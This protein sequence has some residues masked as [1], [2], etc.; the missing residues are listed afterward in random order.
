MKIEGD[1]LWDKTGEPDPEVQQLEEILG[2]LRYQPKPLEIPADLQIGRQRNF[3]RGFAPGLAIAATIA[4][5]L[6]GLALWVG[7]QRLQRGPSEVSKTSSKPESSSN[8]NPAT[9]LLPNKDQDTSASVSSRPGQKQ[10]V[11]PRRHVS[12][13]LMANNT[14][15]SHDAARKERVKNL[16]GDSA[17]AANDLQAGTAA[18]DQLMLGLRVAS[19]KLSLAQR[20]TQESTNPR[21]LIHNQHKIG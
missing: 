18:K 13:S 1:Y 17:L 10:I 12:G 2:T 19:A 7:L 16:P 5:I 21:D 11:S 9:A 20:K 3:F 14:N 8:S 4:M 15:Q 6:V